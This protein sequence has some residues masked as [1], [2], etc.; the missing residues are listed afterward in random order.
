VLAHEDP[1]IV[2]LGG[3]AGDPQA[4]GAGGPEGGRITRQQGDKEAQRAEFVLEPAAVDVPLTVLKLVGPC[5]KY[6]SDR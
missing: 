1:Q 2:V 3:L 5:R 4:I 6:G